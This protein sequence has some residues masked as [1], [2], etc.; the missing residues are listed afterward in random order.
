MSLSGI[1]NQLLQSLLVVF[2]APIL[3]GWVNTCRA[4]LQN[5]GGAGL[6]QPYRELRRLFSKEAVL[7]EQATPLFRATPYILF[8]AMWLAASIVPV[9]ATD[10]PLAPAADII[11]LVGLFTLARFFMALAAMDVGSAFGNLGARRE[12]LV[13]SLSEPALLTAL[14][15]AALVS[16]STALTTIVENI[17]HRHFMLY[18]SMLFAAAAFALVFLAENARIPVDNPDTHLEL[19]M[20]H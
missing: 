20:I 18:P 8:G 17:A 10:L 5:R 7:A 15:I 19:T 13:A 3:L 9:L 6:L 4:W 12:M 14:F 1:L 16:Q 11:A 2:L